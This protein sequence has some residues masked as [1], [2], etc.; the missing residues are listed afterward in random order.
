MRILLDQAV[1]DQRNKGNVALLQA[2]V[3]RL[4]ALW[5]AAQIEVLTEAPHLLKHYC[6]TVHPVGVHPWQDWSDQQARFARMQQTALPTARYLA[7][8]LREEVRHRY[9]ALMTGG[10]RRRLFT[11]SDDAADETEATADWADPDDAPEEEAADLWMPARAM[12]ADVLQALENADLVVATGGGYLCDTDKQYILQVF[13]TLEMAVALGKP[14]VMVGQ[15]VGPLDDPD[16]RARFGRLLPQLD[17]I[18]VREER[19]A[20]PL[21]AGLGVAPERV[22]MTGDDAV[23]MAYAARR[24]HMGAHIGVNLRTARY[25]EVDASYAAKI[26]PVLCAASAKHGAPLMALPISSHPQEADLTVIRAALTGCDNVRVDWRRFDQPA[27]V[28]RKVGDCRVVVTGSFHPAVFALAQGIPVVGLVKSRAYR[29]KFGGLCDQFGPACRLLHL[30]DPDL[31]EQLADAIDD[32]WATAA[33]VRAGLLEAAEHQIAWDR[34]GY[35]RIYEL[36]ASRSP[37]FA[38]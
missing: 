18:L 16:L 9:P 7:L 31:P 14:A 33:D 36:V 15:G 2:A 27:G 37:V 38:T 35:Q 10:L 20:R 12:S 3:A 24:E 21:L 5:P 29:E 1:Y 6:P 13:E 26:R 25:T 34:A 30:D 28:I 4:S 17:L 22:V 11:R 32:A 8:E 19:V 23:E